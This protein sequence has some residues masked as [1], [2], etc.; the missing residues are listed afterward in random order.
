MFNN[1]YAALRKLCV[2]SR[3]VEATP[4]QPVSTSATGL[5]RALL[6]GINY[7]GSEYELKGCINDVA[8]M[9]THLRNYFPSC[10]DYTLLT[11]DTTKKPSRKNILEAI[12]A[13]TTDLKS[14]ENVFLHFSG[15]G[16]TVRD[17]NG[18]EVAGL[19]SCIYPFDAGKMETITDD[20]LR[21]H[22][23]SAIPA[24]SKCFVVL[25]CCHSGTAIDLRYTWQ[26]PSEMSLLHH[27]SK[28]YPATQGEIVFLSG[29]HDTQ[30]SADTVGADRKPC[31]ALT[32]A[33]IDTWKAYGPAIKLKYILWDVHTFLKKRGYTQLPQLS[34]GRYIDINAVF[35][36]RI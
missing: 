9:T 2:S 29:C 25:D 8:A 13:L 10:K 19:D 11:D 35:D 21:L 1:F 28:A 12:K 33:L 23:A 15:H 18:D 6:I 3:P 7:K 24:G 20:E 27:E 36:L 34:L 22:L 30:T 26:V 14:G 17:T 16:G 32:W 4:K 5:K 31:G